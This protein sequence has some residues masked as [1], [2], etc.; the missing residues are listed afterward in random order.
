MRA[1]VGGPLLDRRVGAGL[2]GSAAGRS[3][4]VTCVGGVAGAARLA[5]AG[6]TELIGEGILRAVETLVRARQLLVLP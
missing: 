4:Q 2:T 3:W 6:N 5:I 1:L